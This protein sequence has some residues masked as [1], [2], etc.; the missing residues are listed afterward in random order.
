M[1]YAGVY[2]FTQLASILLN[3]DLNNMVE[4]ETINRFERIHDDIMHAD[5]GKSILSTQ[6]PKIDTP[7]MTELK[8][9]SGS[10]KDT[11]GLMS[12]LTGPTWGHLKYLAIVSGILDVD[13]STFN[14]IVFGNVDY[15]EDSEDSARY[16]AY[17]LSTEYGRW[18][19]KIWPAMRDGRGMDLVRHW[20]GLYPRSWTKKGHE[21]LFGTKAE[22]KAE[23]EEL[24]PNQKAI[25]ILN[26]LDSGYSADEIKLRHWE[27]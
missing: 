23:K 7:L 6:D 22:R 21:W 2:G 8:E 19:N 4:N 10:K 24:N 26:M 1:R 13:E 12:E 20:L 5:P 27:G 25:N 3:T 15:S 14:K 16:T 9:E 11:F 18:K 17:Q